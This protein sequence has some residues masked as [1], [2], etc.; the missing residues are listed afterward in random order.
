[1][2]INDVFSPI[3]VGRPPTDAGDGLVRLE[4]GELRHYN[5]GL[6]GAEPGVFY[7]RS[8]DN[9]MTW[10]KCQ[11]P[12]GEEIADHRS[13]IS[14]D[15]IRL[16]SAKE[17]VGYQGDTI[18]V[19]RRQGGIDGPCSVAPVLSLKTRGEVRPPVFIRGGR[20]ILVSAG[21]VQCHNDVPYLFGVYIL[22]SDDDGYTWCSTQLIT[23]PLT[24]TDRPT[25]QNHLKVEATLTTQEP[26]LVELRDGRIWM[27][28]RTNRDRHHESFSEDGG[29]TWSPPV[30]SRFYA[31]FTMPTIG[32]LN[33]GRLLFS[34]CN[35][36][37]L[38]K[39][40]RTESTFA[41]MGKWSWDGYSTDMFT[42]RDA[43]HIAISEDDGRSWIGFREVWLDPRRNAGDYA[44]TGGVD[45]SV[46]QSQFVELGDN[47]ILLS[48]G[49]HPLHRSMVVFDLGWLYETERREDFTEGLS[50]WS[51]HTYIAGVLGHHAL[52]RQE[53]AW[54]EEHPDGSGRK[55]MRI[56]RPRQPFLIREPRGAVWN[57]PAAFGGELTLRLMLPSGSQGARISLI[58]R[59]INPTDPLVEQYAMFTL[60][61]DSEM[62][63]SDRWRTV[64]LSWNGL[65][66][67]GEQLCVVEVDG[68]ASACIPLRLASVNGVSYLHLQSVAKSEDNL[69]LL[70]ESAGFKKHEDETFPL[71]IPAF[72]DACSG[73]RAHPGGSEHV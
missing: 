73:N 38:P 57:F 70:V 14:G 71:A 41:L 25:D 55:V 44:R 68:E 47:K 72:M 30:P 52:N 39:M 9:G 67:T 60:I 13:P 2:N 50:Q 8:L 36:T 54:L 18:C 42:N 24:E 5:Y 33:D 49:Q 10:E 64:R 29:E 45:R 6:Q 11:L 15:Y 31:E 59:W 65:A 63:G 17:K 43:A 21:G 51:T 16:R 56:A 27:I 35:T 1:M 12:D 23:I 53:G 61:A 22:R 20:R 32:R 66:E 3:F 40:E 26:T 48:L 37:N 58:D 28:V 7:L 19:I 46:H 4:N 62:L 69:G 34:W